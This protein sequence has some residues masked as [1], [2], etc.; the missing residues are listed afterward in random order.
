MRG[1]TLIGNQY[2]AYTTHGL[3][4]VSSFVALGASFLQWNLNMNESPMLSF[5]DFPAIIEEATDIIL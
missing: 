3:P 4:G 5:C 2:G 1:F